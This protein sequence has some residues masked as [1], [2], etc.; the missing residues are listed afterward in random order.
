MDDGQVGPVVLLVRHG[1]SVW[2]DVGRWQG[3]ADPPLSGLGQAQ[4]LDVAP[5]VPKIGRAVSSDLHRARET[6]D[7]LVAA[8]AV[9]V[10]VDARLRERDIGPWTGLTAAEIDVGWPGYRSSGRVAGGSE[11]PGVVDA[12]VEAALREL[13]AS[14]GTLPTLVVTHAGVLDSVV[15]VFS[16]ADPEHSSNLR[17]WAVGADAAG[18]PVVLCPWG[19]G[20]EVRANDG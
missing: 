19:P 7:L 12:R 11:A 1:R 20:D 4:A 9:H 15:R 18:Q 13:V 6:A 10:E 17:G 8:Q 5:F 3:H 2:N 14:S 16:Y